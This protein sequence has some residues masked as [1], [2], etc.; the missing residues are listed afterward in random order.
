MALSRN[1][2]A[3]VSKANQISINWL[4]PINFNN[5]ND[6]LIVTRTITHYP[7]ELYNSSFSNRATDIRP[8]EIYRGRTIVGIN[9]GTISVL[10]NV[11]TDSSA[12]FPT[13]PSL[14]GRLLRDSTSKVHRI[15]SNTSATIT[16]E[17]APA[18]GKYIVLPDFPEDTRIQ[19]NYELDI[20]TSSGA[21]FI[22]NLVYISNGSLLIKEFSVDELANMIFKDG[23]VDKFIIKSN[24]TNTLFFYEPDPHRQF[25]LQFQQNT[26]PKN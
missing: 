15:V 22:S 24:T 21:G 23:N 17:S 5:E 20:R 25:Q 12:T 11:L 9:T 26:E 7:M 4:A 1:F 14:I 8:I 3:S 6:E 19:E 13:T 18:N 2:K 16:L 10:V